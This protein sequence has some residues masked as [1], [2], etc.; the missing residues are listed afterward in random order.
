MKL[1]SSRYG[2]SNFEMKYEA[3]T[4]KSREWG[5][6]PVSGFFRERNEVVRSKFGLPREVSAPARGITAFA[7]GI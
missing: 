6:S 3:R 5:L 2:K 4:K 7:T 1:Y